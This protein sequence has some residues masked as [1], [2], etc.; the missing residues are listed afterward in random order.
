MAVRETPFYR[1][2]ANST[3]YVQFI[4]FLPGFYHNHRFNILNHNQFIP[5]KFATLRNYWKHPNINTQTLKI[6]ILIEESY[7]NSEAIFRLPT[8]IRTRW[9]RRNSD[10]SYCSSG[11][12][13]SPHVLA[14]FCV[15]P[16]TARRNHRHHL[17]VLVEGFDL[18]YGSTRNV[19]RTSRIGKP[20]T[21]PSPPRRRR[22]RR[23]WHRRRPP[24]DA[25]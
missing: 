19:A 9:C 8:A 2:L 4:P 25:G 23:C 6:H 11:R 7:R 13:C 12:H 17:G 1:K 16:A 15:I 18:V 22:C 21:A 20:T 3:G 10:R 24:E 14:S 5:Q